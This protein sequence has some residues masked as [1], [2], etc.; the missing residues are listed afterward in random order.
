MDSQLMTPDEAA[1]YLRVSRSTLKRWRL[2]GKLR[3]VYLSERLVRFHR[4]EIERL[5][6]A[7]TLGGV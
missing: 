6:S 3:V 5:A 2:T 4:E 7:G 1:A